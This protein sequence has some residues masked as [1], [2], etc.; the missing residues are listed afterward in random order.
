MGIGTFRGLMTIILM[1]LFVGLVFWAFS[2]RRKKDFE[3]AARLPL[4]DDRRPDSSRSR[5]END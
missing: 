1:L 2:R 3:A 5:T 4:D